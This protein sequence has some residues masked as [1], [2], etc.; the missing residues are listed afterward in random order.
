MFRPW[1]QVVQITNPTGTIETMERRL[2]HYKSMILK[3]MQAA[4]NKPVICNKMKKI[5]SQ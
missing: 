1:N 5:R 3:G 2:T 4:G